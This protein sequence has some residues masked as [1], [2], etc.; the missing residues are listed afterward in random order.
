MSDVKKNHES[1]EKNSFE[2]WIDERHSWLQ[3]AA[4]LLIE[5]KKIPSDLEI[6]NLAKLCIN[7]AL[8]EKDG[9]SKVVPGALAQAAQR[10]KLHI[11]KI[12]GVTGVN[13]IKSGAS[14][15]FGD[16][17]LTVIYGSNGSGKTG[18]SRL[19]KQMCGSR[20]KD[21][22]LGNV[23]TSEQLPATAD[24][25][26][27]LNGNT[28]S[29][30]WTLSG[31]ALSSLRHV[32]VFDTRTAKMYMGK[33]EAT[34]EPSRMRFNSSLIAIC[35]RVS[36]Y[37]NQEKSTFISKLP[38]VPVALITTAP[39]QWVNTLQSTTKLEVIEEKCQFS[40]E[41][42]DERISAESVLAEKDV[43]GRLAMIT[44]GRLAHQR[45]KARLEDL[46]SALSDVA[47]QTLITAR[48]D[49]QKKRNIAAKEAVNVFSNTAL[50]GVGQ[51]AWMALWKHAK[52]FSEQHAYPN[53]H[54]PCTENGSRCVLCQQVMGDDG[55][56][57]MGHFQEYVRGKLETDAKTSENL[58]DELTKKIP[59]LPTE[60]DWLVIMNQLSISED[61]ARRYLTSLILRRQNFDVAENT[62]GVNF[63]DWNPIDS[64]CLNI[65][66]AF[67]VE[68]MTLKEM[69]KDGRRDKLKSRVKELHA[70]QWLSQNKFSIFE[71]RERLNKI[72]VYDSAIK[73]TNTHALTKKNNELAKAELDA[74][75]QERF[76][77]EL[78]ELGGARLRVKL[79]SKK[80][81]KGKITF[82]LTLQGN[83]T[84][85]PAEK[86][87]SEGE[88]RI[89]A[90]AAFLADITG[91]GQKAPFIFDDP[92]SSLDQDFEERVATRLVRLAIERQVIIFTHRL[93][94]LT[95]VESSTKKIRDQAKDEG[96]E[97][98]V[99]VSVETLRKLG[100]SAGIVAK[101]SLRDS[102]PA[103]ALARIKGEFLP[104]LR[105]HVDNGDV[106][107]FE[108][109]AWQTCSEF[110]IILEKCV[111]SV[112]LNE[113]LMRFRRDIQTKGRLVKLTKIQQSDCDLIDSLMTKYSIFEHSQSDELPAHS[114]DIQ[115]IEQDV[116]VLSSWVD[117]YVKRA[118]N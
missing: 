18:F 107:A 49:A 36:A 15:V 58:R 37:L 28:K 64:A 75:Y 72:S 17:K 104:Q 22:L 5:S 93:S 4:H 74:G 41:F 78:N 63:F 60:R 110:R 46:K 7:E 30:P 40:R 69:Q 44:R 6:I 116:G 54:F 95:L 70:V 91:S 112:L 62:S 56:E 102:K 51:S 117:N 80:Q 99:S 83:V 61:D 2:R 8:G 59:S 73:L 3:S 16:K 57:R 50:E 111:E 32:H 13:A 103:K 48:Y 9:Y 45:I 25:E 53:N 87:L 14:L 82:G 114:P 109:E 39:I 43:V 88:S 100:G 118:I 71:E 106:D 11:N 65:S 108:R 19:L 98:P 68:E 24:I 29:F 81:G 94:F 66:N 79:E 113:V 26:I 92:I 67:D 77:Q 42:N 47:I 38:R 33:N 1:A 105:K 35:D 96:L 97:P 27:S 52:E 12:T 89:V 23:F 101:L 84:A 20:A 76:S 115:E 10:S 55:R 34:Y 86:V 31:G 85:L 90:L 21:E